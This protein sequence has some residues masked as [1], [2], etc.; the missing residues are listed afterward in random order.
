[1]KILF[2]F[3][4]M[5]VVFGS[6][7]PSSA[8]QPITSA[9]LQQ[10][11][12]SKQK[13]LLAQ[14]GKSL[15]AE[16]T[17]LKNKGDLDNFLVFQA[18]RERLNKEASVPL[19]K[20]SPAPFMALSKAHYQNVGQ[21]MRQYIQALDDFIKNEVMAGRIEA[22]KEAKAE[23]DK[24]ALLLEQIGPLID[25]PIAASAKPKPTESEKLD[26]SKFATST[27]TQF[28]NDGSPN[29]EKVPLKD[30]DGLWNLS[31]LKTATP[32]ASS[33]IQGYPTR[34]AIKN[35]N[36]GWYHNGSS[37]IPDQM[38]AWAEI[39]LGEEYWVKKVAFGSNH[40]MHWHDRAA[41]KFLILV[42][43]EYHPNSKSK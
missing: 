11:Y 8:Q 25:E 1:M 24:A 16:M 40:A 10:T 12:A 13:N 19:P 22:A 32:N 37:W 43:T 15:D 29:P 30:K 34:H 14:Y 31:L 26:T 6:V 21:L 36:D 35:L 18:E 5:I 4:I 28:D 9:L 3:I 2:T 39:D 17:L 33:L 42:A 20:E 7:T 41:S 27:R 38:P 23:K